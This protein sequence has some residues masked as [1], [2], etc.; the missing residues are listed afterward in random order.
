MFFPV[1]QQA[2]Y[3]RGGFLKAV[4]MKFYRSPA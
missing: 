1:Y 4:R 2:V 3:E